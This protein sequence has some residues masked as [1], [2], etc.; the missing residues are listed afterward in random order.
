[1][2]KIVQYVIALLLF[3]LVIFFS[4][5][6]LTESPPVWYDEGIY[7][8]SANNLAFY[9]TTG[10]RVSPDV[11]EPSSEFITVGYP[12]IYPLALCFKLFG[13]GIASARSLM[14]IFVIALVI[15][16]F[17]LSKRLWGV[18]F[19]SAVLALLVTFPP[20]YGNGKSVLGE[21]PGL[22]YLA[23]FLLL[24]NTA[25]ISSR[26]R[27]IWIIL[28]GTSAGLAVTTK[29]L[30]L[31]LLPI[32]AFGV[33]IS[34]YRNKISVK[35]VVAFCIAMLLPVLAWFCVQFQDAVSLADILSYY[36]NPYR[37]DNIAQVVIENF[38]KL[39]SNT[40]TLYFVVVMFV[41]ILSLIQ[42]WRS[43][44][45]ISVEEVMC[46]AFSCLVFIA[47]LRTAGWFRYIFPAQIVSLVFF[48]YSLS[49]LLRRFARPIVIMLVVALSLFGV[50]QISFDSWVAEAYQSYKTAYW[51]DYFSKVS[52]DDVLFFYDTPEVAIFAPAWNYY[53][54][55]SPAGT[56]I[57][58]VGLSVINKGVPDSIMIRTDAWDN[59]KGTDRFTNY[60]ISEQAYKYTILKRRMD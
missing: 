56:V 21:V 59:L 26:D 3:C 7:I 36:A 57:G 46:F 24:F 10:L 47:Y 40:G 1:M 5:Y 34:W 42:R 25:I 17:I 31:I 19:A 12:L 4:F 49:I 43:K 58:K 52:K 20:L 41:W 11:I 28:A 6:K 45:R 55:I 51:Q 22:L 37:I 15:T 29:P 39:F 54:Y 48:P 14:A 2:Q 23:T 16:L 27:L 9:G 13:M 8:Q 50:Y 30:F 33:W 53:Q 44:E 38:L 35:A 60:S 32:V 18:T